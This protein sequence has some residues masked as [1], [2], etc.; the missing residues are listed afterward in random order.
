MFCV[1]LHLSSADPRAK[2]YP[3]MENPLATLG[4]VLTYLSWVMVI[5]PIYMRDR[6]PLQLRNTLIYYNAAQ[7]LLSTYMF[8]EHL[9]AGWLRDYNY[10]CETVN[11]DDGAQSR[12]VSDFFAASN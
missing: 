10:S 12:R 2:Q 6:K 8:Y 9:M 1:I 3:F 7:V 4:M 11:Y 5:G